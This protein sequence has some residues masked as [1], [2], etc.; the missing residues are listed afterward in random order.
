MSEEL[1]EEQA[2]QAELPEGGTPDD[3]DLT[4]EQARE[5]TMAKLEAMASGGDQAAETPPV[6]VAPVEDAPPAPDPVEAAKALLA[7]RGFAVHTPQ[8]HAEMMARD[9]VAQQSAQ[10]PQPEPVAPEPFVPKVQYP[11][12][13]G[14]MEYTQLLEHAAMQI[15]EQMSDHKVAA[16]RAEMERAL[17]PLREAQYRQARDQVVRL[18]ASQK[19]QEMGVPDQAEAFAAFF[20]RM[21]DE[22]L[23]RYGQPGQETLTELVDLGLDRIIKRVS[24]SKTPG[25]VPLPR[26]EDVETTPTDPRPGTHGQRAAFER[27]N[28]AKMGIKFE[29]LM[30]KAEL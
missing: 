7:E 19:A 11:D 5:A 26:G 8:E 18:G 12:N 1:L 6:G 29:D 2:I 9:M 27:S 4:N 20:S 30:K 25:P 17:Q 10:Q 23:R 16:L 14:D 22:D 3:G 28:A 13:A 15:A 21:P 24:E